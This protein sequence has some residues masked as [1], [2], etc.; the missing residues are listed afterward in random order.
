MIN[1]TCTEKILS[2]QEDN[3]S[4]I[5]FRILRKIT[6]RHSCFFKVLPV[7]NVSSLVLT[8]VWYSQSFSDVGFAIFLKNFFIKIILLVYSMKR[9]VNTESA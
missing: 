1:Q 4:D 2:V 8:F 5:E 9:A 7:R 3:V 6:S